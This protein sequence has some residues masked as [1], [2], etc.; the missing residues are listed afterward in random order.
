MKKTGFV[1]LS[2]Y[3][4]QKNNVSSPFSPGALAPCVR[5]LF[6]VKRPAS[7]ADHSL[8][9]NTEVTNVWIHPSTPRIPTWTDI[10]PVK[11]TECLVKRNVDLTGIDL[12]QERADSHVDHDTDGQ[13]ETAVRKVCIG[14]GIV[15]GLFSTR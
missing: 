6:G 1:Q 3:T 2:R 13:Y 15:G 8:P 5:G 14:L 4:Q 12:R 9:P 11:S 7:K 10:A